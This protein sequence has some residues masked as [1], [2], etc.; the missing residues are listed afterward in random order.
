MAIFLDDEGNPLD[1]TYSIDN[2]DLILHSRGGAKT[3]GGRNVDYGRALRLLLKRIRKS[4]IGLA[5]IL[6]D[7][8]RTA[9]LPVDQ[10]SIFSPSDSGL[11]DKKLFTLLSRRMAKV[12]Q[13]PGTASGN[14]T[15]R[16]RFIFAENLPK[17]FLTETLGGGS[18]KR[19]PASLLNSL[20]E[21]LIWEAVEQLRST[22]DFGEFVDSTKFDVLLESGQRL[23]PKAVFGLAASM[24][25]GF[26]VKPHHF[27][28]GQ[29]TICF[30]KIRNAGFAIVTKPDAREIERASL[31]PEDV[32]WTE[33]ETR[34][35][36]HLRRE[37]K[38]GLS[39]AK[40]RDYIAQNG[41]LSCE[42][43]GLKPD[44]VYGS[45]GE[46][47]IEVHHTIPV[48]DMPSGYQ[49]RLE[50]LMCLCANC[51]RVVHSEMRAANRNLKA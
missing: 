44:E 7:S 28:G 13:K 9:N 4:D 40:K 51:H 17:E 10:K 16:I 19:M 38:S 31:S 49:T 24:A 33:G 27:S 47:C 46:S 37:R 50:D 1:A 14:Q 21:Q 5:K 20:D 43:C 18:D 25:F 29:N 48:S 26:D 45:H 22:T 36:S 8:S 3:A 30:E 35:V 15:K 11:E 12:G 34:L 42:R 2:G 41:H 32:T 39:K 6:V 23:P